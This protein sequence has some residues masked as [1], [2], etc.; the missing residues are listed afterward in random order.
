MVNLGISITIL[1]DNLAA[2]GLE[3]EHGFSLWIQVAG[4]NIL[5]DTGC[6]SAFAHNADQL[7][8]ALDQVDDIVVSH[9]HYD[10]TGN[11]AG[12]LHNARRP[13]RLHLHT[14]AL[15]A[16]YS[17]HADPRE[18]GM[19]VDSVA[20]VR[21]LPPW[22]LNWIQGPTKIADG[23]W[24]TG[25][26]PRVQCDEDTGGPFFNDSEGNVIDLIDDDQSIW[27]ETNDGL[28]VCLGCCHAGVINTLHHILDVTGRTSIY[29]VLGGLHLV[30]A[31]T[32]RIDRTA[33]AFRRLGVVLLLPCHC[34][35]DSAIQRLEEQ[36][37]TV[38]Q[39]G[40]AGQRLALGPLPGVNRQARFGVH[41][42]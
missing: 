41:D 20:A 17:I 29:A 5:F 27:I 33:E 31:D 22:R 3:A 16:R 12:V 39:S 4:R 26:V 34:T 2:Y 9:G 1:S 11:L 21:D 28:V 30:H 10:H 38:L 36:L 18:I 7:G 37:G 6:G 25:F 23:V 15:K 13:V 19:P 24:V 8:I 35:G 40:F 42:R 32:A 14:D